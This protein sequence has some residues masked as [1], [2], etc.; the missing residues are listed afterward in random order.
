MQDHTFILSIRAGSSG[1]EGE[2]AITMFSY[3]LFWSVAALFTKIGT[4]KKLVIKRRKN[5]IHFIIT[6]LQ[7]ISKNK[8]S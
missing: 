3:L 4:A 7:R 1:T 6:E 8:Y 5:E 2:I